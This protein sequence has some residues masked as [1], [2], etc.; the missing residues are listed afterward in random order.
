MHWGVGGWGK[1][2]D[3][4]N[5]LCTFIFWVLARPE[6]NSVKLGQGNAS[7]AEGRA[8]EALPERCGHHH[9]H[10]P[11]RESGLGAGERV[12][13]E[14]TAPGK[15]TSLLPRHYRPNQD[16]PSDTSLGDTAKLERGPPNTN[17]SSASKE[18]KQPLLLRKKKGTKFHLSVHNR[19]RVCSP[20]RPPFLIWEIRQAPSE[21]GRSGPAQRLGRAGGSPAPHPRAPHEASSPFP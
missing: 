4:R 2:E 9:C 12:L 10:R 3:S 5:L 17:L 6:F 18:S 19:N 21:T 8:Q 11:P 16:L 13:P 7:E 1:Q 14:W 15:P 20:A